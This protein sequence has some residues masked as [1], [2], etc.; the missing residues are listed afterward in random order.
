M[1]QRLGPGVLRMGGK[2]PE[3]YPKEGGSIEFQGL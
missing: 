1:V 3:G 2:L